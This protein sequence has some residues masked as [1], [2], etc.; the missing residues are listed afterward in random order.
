MQRRQGEARWNENRQMWFI[1]VQRDGIRKQFSS[2]VP[3]R[4]GKR[5]AE[6]KADDW[7]ENSCPET[8]RLWNVWSD[9]IT[10]KELTC[11][12]SYL[13]QLKNFGKNHILPKI[14]NKTYSK[15]T[16]QDWQNCID[17]AYRAGLAQKS[18]KLLRAAILNLSRF[19]RKRRLIS[20]VPETL[21]IPHAARGPKQHAV[22]SPEDI[23]KLFAANAESEYIHGFR[24]ALLTGMRP[25]E[26]LGLK[27]SDVDDSI[28]HIRRAKNTFGEITTGKNKN[29]IRDIGLSPRAIAELEAQRKEQ[30]QQGIISQW[31]FPDAE[32]L[33]VAYQWKRFCEKN[34]LTV[35]TLYE[36]RHTM[37]SYMKSDVPEH[38]LKRAIG[39]SE[40]MDT[41]GVYGHSVRGDTERTG[42]AIAS[43]FDRILRTH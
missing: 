37:I 11:G 23:Q 9:Y 33:K 25:G 27:W 39:H 24:L 43:V 6:G 34:G 5:I 40:S 41:F 35:C 32:P 19:A 28:L 15:I 7:I 17:T 21:T 14:G 20:A 1:K 42:K 26:L 31:V 12:T 38:L 13:R 10:S 8:A 30:L 36:L 3:G 29:A 18:L 16:D 22:L 2:A 4:K